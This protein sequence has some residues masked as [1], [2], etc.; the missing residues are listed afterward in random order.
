M[1]VFSAAE[2]VLSVFDD[3]PEA[4]GTFV[5]DF[6]QRFIL[7]FF[8]RPRV[9]HCEPINLLNICKMGNYFTVVFFKPQPVV[10]EEAIEVFETPPAEVIQVEVIEEKDQYVL[11]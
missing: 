6:Q 8:T 7:N 9:A 3:N 1:H 5:V 4:Y 11:D 10:I 2:T